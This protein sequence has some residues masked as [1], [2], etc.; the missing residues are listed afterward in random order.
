MSGD[1]MRAP[2]NEPLLAQGPVMIVPKHIW[3]SYTALRERAEMK[4]AQLE[5]TEY[6]DFGGIGT[7]ED[8]LLCGTHETSRAAYIK[9]LKWLL[10][11]GL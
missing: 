6:D 9:V 3:D 2:E 8:A 4:L 10:N 11:R 5:G 7:G 1:L